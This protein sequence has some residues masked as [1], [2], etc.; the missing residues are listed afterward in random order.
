[1]FVVG[2]WIFFGV[3]NCGCFV[4]SSGE[5]GGGKRKIGNLGVKVRVEEGVISCLESF[6]NVF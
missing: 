4:K 6:V 3:F 5:E 2:I 1:M